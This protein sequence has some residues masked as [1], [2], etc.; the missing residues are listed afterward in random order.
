VSSAR[1]IHRHAG[2]PDRLSLAH[3]KAHPGIRAGT[4]PQVR[5]VPAQILGHVAMSPGTGN[6]LAHEV[7]GLAVDQRADLTAST[8]QVAVASSGTSSERDLVPAARLDKR[9]PNWFSHSSSSV[10]RVLCRRGLSRRA[11]CHP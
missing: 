2:I 8:K 4:D 5:R 10:G 9:H 3:S 6:W 1:I 7:P 11:W